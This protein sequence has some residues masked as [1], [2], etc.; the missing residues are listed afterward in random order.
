M[1]GAAG[2]GG[3][4]PA[5][6]TLLGLGI[7]EAVAPSL[8]RPGTPGARSSSCPTCRRDVPSPE[9]VHCRLP[10]PCAG[11]WEDAGPCTAWRWSNHRTLLRC[12]GFIQLPVA[13]SMSLPGHGGSSALPWVLEVPWYG[14][15]AV[16]HLDPR[17]TLPL[18]HT[19]LLCC[20]PS[21]LF[22]TRDRRPVKALCKAAH[23]AVWGH[24]WMGPPGGT[25]TAVA[26]SGLAGRRQAELLPYPSFVDTVFPEASW[27]KKE[28]TPT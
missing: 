18:P 22:P 23:S 16:L 7:S 14:R 21:A 8:C 20:R 2:G 26:G 4:F 27:E 1:E 25:G 5:V 3:G 19:P 9:H 28:K 6:E 17:G 15:K 13:A 10:R 24:A 12:E 11:R